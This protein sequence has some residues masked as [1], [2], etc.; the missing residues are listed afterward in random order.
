MI[1]CKFEDGGDGELRHLVVH[2]LAIKDGKILLVKRA[3]GILEAGKWGLPGGFLDRDETL[4]KCAVRELKEETG[5]DCTVK[6]LMRVNSN[7]NRRNDNG[8]QNVAFE[9]FVEVGEKT[10]TPDWEQTEVK[11]FS[12]NE[13]DLEDMAFDHAKTIKY[14]QEYLEKNIKLPIVE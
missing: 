12:F 1:T 2:A 11:W 5:Y 9:I 4:E 8:R 13:I 14:I 10:G 7:P 6:G 3:P